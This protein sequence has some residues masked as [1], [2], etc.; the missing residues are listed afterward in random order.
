MKFIFDAVI[1][2]VKELYGTD[3][4]LAIINIQET[5]K[6]FVG[7][8]TL[9]TFPLIKFSKKSPEQTGNEIGEYFANNLTEIAGFNVV[10]G[11]L[12]LSLTLPQEKNL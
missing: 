2:A 1:K 10:K 9:V 11:F 4:D 3:I 7:Q 6:E 8:V 12:N 5:R